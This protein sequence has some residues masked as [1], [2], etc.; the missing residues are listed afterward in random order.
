MDYPAAYVPHGAVTA[1]QADGLAAKWVL[2]RKAQLGGTI[3]VY[4]P[5][6]RV[7][8]SHPI[9]G[10]LIRQR[11]AV[12]ATWKTM[13]GT[14]WSGGPVIAAWPDR[15]HLADIAKDRRTRALCVLGWNEKDTEGWA[16]AVSP[17]VLAGKESFATVNLA[18]PIVVAALTTLTHLVNQN[19]ALTDPTDKDIA[20]TILRE[21]RK[22][23][24]RLDP[25]D[26]YSWALA[27]G[28]NDRGAERL[29]QL[30]VDMNA[31]KRPRAS[32]N[33]LR[34]DIYSTWV[35]DA[36]GSPDRP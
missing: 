19:N 22:Q 7:A 26:I 4:L 18:D 9:L 17:E 30:I 21:L 2:E 28:W 1:E 25:D 29:R 36:E 14:G 34:P 23:G 3:L 20:V 13:M 27:Q 32:G 35:T 12:E 6:K 5:T 24:H 11:A 15:T 10:G 31:G 33:P 16:R 8:D